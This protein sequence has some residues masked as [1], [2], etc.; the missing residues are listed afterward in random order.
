M[1]NYDENEAEN[2]MKMKNRSHRYDMNRLRPTLG[3]LI[4][5]PTAYFF[6]KNFPSSPLLLK[7]LLSF[8]LCESNS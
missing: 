8:F 1:I 5:V 7:S 2:E 6:S 3:P 4:S